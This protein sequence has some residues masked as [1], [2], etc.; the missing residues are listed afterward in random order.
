MEQQKIIRSILFSA[1]PSPNNERSSS[2]PMYDSLIG[3]FGV[4]PVE[5]LYHT[6]SYVIPSTLG[7]PNNVLRN[8]LGTRDRGVWHR[9]RA[10]PSPASSTLATM[11]RSL[12][13]TQ[14]I[15]QGDYLDNEFDPNTLT[16][17]QLIGVLTHHQIRYPTPYTKAKLV[18]SFLDEIRPRVAKFRKD[19]L[20]TENSLASDDGITDGV[21]GRPLN[22]DT[23]V[24]H[25]C[26]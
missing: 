3:S 17:S 24:A 8:N 16:V 15:N 2:G 10:V 26:P 12:T 13:A 23:K 20:K 6:M 18:Q 25:F 19:R 5:L 1:S 22:A 11:S 9:V 4:H 14:V 21:T 7:R